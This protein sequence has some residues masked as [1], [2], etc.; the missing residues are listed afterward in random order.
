MQILVSTDI[1]CIHAQ[2]TF[3]T[4]D[5]R[6]LKKKGKIKSAIQLHLNV[7]SVLLLHLL[8]P[9]V[10]ILKN[11]NELGA[12]STWFY[13]KKRQLWYAKD[14][15]SSPSS[16][17]SLSL[18]MMIMNRNFTIF[19]CQRRRKVIEEWEL[20]AENTTINTNWQ[21]QRTRNTAHCSRESMY[22]PPPSKTPPTYHRCISFLL[23]YTQRRPRPA[24]SQFIHSLIQPNERRQDASTK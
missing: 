19:V 14:D 20:D 9:C 3:S 11:L 18:S 12:K 5:W 17:L 10:S 24:V 2:L 21:Y 6:F 13:K 23:S 1:K 15:L 4:G 16:L 8:F 7:L 22:W